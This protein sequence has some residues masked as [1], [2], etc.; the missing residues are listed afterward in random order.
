MIDVNIS[1]AI[2]STDEEAEIVNEACKKRDLR[3]I[4]SR[5]YGRKGAVDYLPTLVI[6]SIGA[7]ASGL[8]GELGKD[9]YEKLKEAIK[10][11]YEKLRKTNNINPDLR[12]YIDGKNEDGLVI[13]IP[14]ESK[15]AMIISLERL[16]EEVK[17]KKLSGGI[18]FNAKIKEWGTYE[19]IEKWRKKGQI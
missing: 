3:P 14:M 7:I 10:E 6:L 4:I 16:P 18:Y 17:N 11:I 19:D 13:N 1:M 9:V 15:S 8:L 12:I 2:G 5:N